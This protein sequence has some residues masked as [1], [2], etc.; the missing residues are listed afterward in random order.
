MTSE[1]KTALAGFIDIAS[2]YLRDGYALPREAY[3]FSDDSDAIEAPNSK[4]AARPLVMVIGEGLD[5]NEGPEGQLLGKMLASIGL[6][7]DKNCCVIGISDDTAL[8]HQQIEQFKP[9]CLFC[10]G[11]AAARYLFK[12]KE[13]INNLRG[14]FRGYKTAGGISI[15]I[16]FSFHPGDILKDGSLKRSAWED[17]K[18]MKAKLSIQENT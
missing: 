6:F 4:T 15:P 7:P 10:T 8:L 3:K 5:G 17:L 2:D 12:T 13:D 9:L 18:K 16:L 1:E 14:D 11:E